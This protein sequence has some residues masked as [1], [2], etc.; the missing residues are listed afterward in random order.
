MIACALLTPKGSAI[1]GVATT[2]PVP[3]LVALLSLGFAL[4]A[5]SRAGLYCNHQDLSPKYAG[6]AV[7]TLLENRCLACLP[8]P[9]NNSSD[10]DVDDDSSDDDVDNYD[11]LYNVMIYCSIIVAIINIIQRYQ[12]WSSVDRTCL[13][14]T[15]YKKY[16]TIRGT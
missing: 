1:A 3:I 4:G 5:W 6:E 14:D 13:Y 9:P 16:N 2:A 15:R 8:A 11:V 10:D 12:V 7:L